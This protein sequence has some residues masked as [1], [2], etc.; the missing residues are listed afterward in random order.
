MQG[1]ETHSVMRAIYTGIS[2]STSK[3]FAI[4]SLLT[5]MLL[6][7]GCASGGSSSQPWKGKNASAKQAPNTLEANTQQIQSAN[8]LEGKEQA[9]LVKVAILLP[10]TGDK[11]SI[12]ESM[13]KAA[14]MAVFDLGHDGFELLPVDSKG[15]EEG[16]KLA[17]QAALNQGAQLLLGP[18]FA[19]EVR[20]AKSIASTSNVNIIA[21]S[22][23]WTLADNKTFLIS[24]LPFDQVNRV[25]QY[26]SATGNKRI[27]LLSP[28]DTYGNGVVSAFQAKAEKSGIK[29][30]KIVRF[31][32]QDPELANIVRQ[33]SEYDLRQTKNNKSAPYD[34]VLITAGG[35]TA[36]AI[37]SY[38]SQYG[39]T[40]G[41]VRRLGTG[42]LD[43]QALAKDPSLAG[44][45]FA[46]PSPESRANFEQRY[47]S[48]YYEKPQ[49]LT[50]LAY[51]ATALSAILA[52]SG[53]KEYGQPAYSQ[54]DL[55]NPNGFA[56]VDGIFRFRPDGIVER[57]LAILEYQNGRIVVIDKAPKTFQ[58][59]TN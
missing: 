33:F 4:L 36:R 31:S 57:G 3:F 14:Q 6:L 27:G 21:F 22:T 47:Q 28:N 59:M 30:S 26:A 7:Q 48:N 25:L 20:G 9:Q 19:D 43:D 38:M 29:N 24:F 42:L 45:W 34:A 51:D 54:R 56:G 12:G 17:A 15:T 49:R 55:S 40:P 8:E 35:N 41:E 18:V 44:A 50:S 52:R 2:S 23:D 46:A 32:P 13:L 39:M 53:I 58:T 11:A 1:K 5:V 16:G 37:A 10:L